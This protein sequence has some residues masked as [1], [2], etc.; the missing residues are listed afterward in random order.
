MLARPFLTACDV[1]TL[2]GVGRPK[3]GTSLSY[4]NG[5]CFSLSLFPPLTKKALSGTWV[6]VGALP[7]VYQMFKADLSMES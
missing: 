2:P 7:R 1:G 6:S 4:L 3:A 5:S